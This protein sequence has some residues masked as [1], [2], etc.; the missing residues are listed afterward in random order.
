MKFMQEVHAVYQ[1]A[2]AMAQRSLE[3]SRKLGLPACPAV[4]EALVD[5]RMI[6]YRQDLG[7]MNIPVSL[8]VGVAQANQLSVLYS[9]D[10]LPVSLPNSKFA[11]QW[12]Q[13]YIQHIRESGLYGQIQCYEYLGKFYVIDGLM[14][15]S[16]LKFHK[17]PTVR[18]HVIRLMPVRTDAKAIVQYYDFLSHF[19]L[20]RLYQLQFTRPGHF[21]KLQIA[22]GHDPARRWTD[23][24]RKYFLAIWPKVEC[25]FQKS[26][27]DDLRITAAD[28]MVLLLEKYTI[29]QISRMELWMLARVFQ[30]LWK[31]FYALSHPDLTLIETAPQSEQVLQTASFDI[32]HSDIVLTSPSSL[33]PLPDIT[34]HDSEC[35]YT[36]P[37]PPRVRGFLRSQNMEK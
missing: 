25:A 6:S 19:R 13:I 10:F 36:S 1:Q 30:M 23:L 33:S 21:A 7:V 8:I 14:S 2:H 31:E 26:Y 20:T 5:K 37:D 18:S 11:N 28:A 34:Y 32:A 3:K 9:R 22:M 4:L 27:E 16:I 15:V 35:R 17:V 29:A 12:R 24:D